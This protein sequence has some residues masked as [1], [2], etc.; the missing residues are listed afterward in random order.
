MINSFLAFIYKSM[1]I[2]VSFAETKTYN[3]NVL[4]NI[5]KTRG[6]RNIK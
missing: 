2:F 3:I 6:I 4:S 1:G 5:F